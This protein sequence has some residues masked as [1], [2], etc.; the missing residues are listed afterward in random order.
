MKN[1]NLKRI[2]IIILGIL[3]LGLSACNDTA[4]P[5]EEPLTVTDSVGRKVEVP[6]DPEAIAT[7]DP[8]AGQAVIMYGYGAKMPATVN[9]VKRDMLLQEVCPT[10]A[11]A[12]VVKESGSMNAEAVL[13]LGID[14]LYVKSDMYSNEA[15]REKIET[16]NIPYIVID[17]NNM[18]EHQEA[19][20][21]MGE[22]LGAEEKAADIVEYYERS[23]QRVEERVTE[24]PE[25][26]RPRLYHAVNEATRTDA[27]G[28]LSADWIATT[29]VT[30]VSLGKD[31]A[32]QGEKHIT[33][34]EEIYEW[35]PDVIICSE[36][37]VAEF[38]LEDVKW[39]G[40]RA[41][42][43]QNV[44]QV[45]IGVSRWGHPSSSE[46]PLTIT[47]L[48]K[49]LYPER[50]ED[51]DMKEEMSCFYRTFYDHEVSDETL[52]LILSGEGIR[53]PNR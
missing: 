4:P 53:K 18:E 5:A 52:D 36:G 41:V 7:L 10:L 34:L 8:F 44:H 30:N 19:F 11:D 15:E 39:A 9:G 14:L 48:A 20:R 28:T 43:K 27:E 26:D 17:Y 12:T 24:I 45:P 49:T 21:I 29:G 46:T 25:G 42:R 38:I 33:T 31:L 47:W 51:I 32:V 50:F 37:G 22:S 3:I 16:L 6:A 40:L 23:I 1:S 2:T 35:D 13:S